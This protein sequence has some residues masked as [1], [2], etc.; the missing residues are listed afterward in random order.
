MEKKNGQNKKPFLMKIVIIILMVLLVIGVRIVIKRVQKFTEQRQENAFTPSNDNTFTEGVKCQEKNSK[1]FVLFGKNLPLPRDT[2]TQSAACHVKN[3]TKMGDGSQ[4]DWSGDGKLITFI[5]KINESYELY[6]MSADG[7]NRHC[8]TC[9]GSLPAEFKNKHKGKAVF[10]PPDSRYLLFS[11]ENENGDHGLYTQPGIG[12][13]HDFWVTD[14]QSN[15]FWRLTKNS[16]GSATQYPRFSSDGSKLLWSQRPEKV[17]G[18]MWQFGCEYGFWQLKLADFTINN[19]PQLSNIASIEPAGK[20]YYEPH[21]FL[22]GSNSKI[23]MT[24]QTSSTKSAFYLD[25]YTYDL[26][27]Q[28]LTN[29]LSADNIHHEMTIYSPNGRKI[30][31]MTGPFI[32]FLRGPHKTDL[33]L[34]DADG[35]NRVRLTYFNEPDNKDYAGG[36][37]QIQKESWNPA[38]TQ[39]I[40]AY[41]NHKTKEDALFKIDFNGSC[42]N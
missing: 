39:M 1:L 16:R 22:P 41:Y 34:M 36:T 13:N 35:K 6:V 15:K 9:E 37:V 20:G 8:I 27:S 5:D 11:V 32:G 23:I 38:G 14:L 24:A 2:G 10:Y 25:V 12:E 31:Y 18:A 7:S 26:I 21:G 4:P 33:Y 17:E 28:K 30:S 19:N 40:S 42:G 29:L 3:I